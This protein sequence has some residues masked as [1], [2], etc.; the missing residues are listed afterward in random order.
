MLRSAGRTFGSHCRRRAALS[1]CTFAAEAGEIV[2]VVGANGAGKTTLLRLIAGDLRLTAG[3]ILVLGRGAGTRPA[4]R[5]VG[6]APDPPIAPPLLTGLEWLHILARHRSS[7]HGE[8]ARLVGAALDAAELHEFV[9]RRIATYSRGMAQRLALAAAV[10]CGTRVVV[11]DETLSGIDPLT[12]RRL[13]EHLRRLAESGRLIVIASHDL[14]SLERLATR[15]L[16]LAK[17]RLRADVPMAMLVSERVA[18][19]TL[20]GAALVGIDRVL[21]MYPG[22]VRTGYGAAIPLTR[23]VTVEQILG[24]LRQER[25]AVAASRVRYRALEDI[26]VAVADGDER[27]R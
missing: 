11:L 17:G 12:H 23:G 10:I 4:R 1:E 7:T 15:A 25:I 13:R 2:G 20:S 22:S 9:R 5:M 18:E 16:V 8:R 21:A 6:F 14:S 27:R 26:L 3:T 19:L 24:T